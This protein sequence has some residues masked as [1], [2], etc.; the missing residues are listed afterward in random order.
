MDVVY[1]IKVI[2]VFVIALFVPS[3][4]FA[5]AKPKR[6]V[7][8]D[9]QVLNVKKQDYKPQSQKTVRSIKTASPAKS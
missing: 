8:K 2:F 4:L 6:D 9:I 7:T 3:I 1:K 5:Q